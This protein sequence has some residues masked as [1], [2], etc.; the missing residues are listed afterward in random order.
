MQCCD[1]VSKNQGTGRDLAGKP[2]LVAIHTVKRNSAYPPPT[3]GGKK[4]GWQL[5]IQRLCTAVQVLATRE[6]QWLA[7]CLSSG[8]DGCSA[9]PSHD[10]AARM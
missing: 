4:R 9:L 8:V 2:T 3:P 1:A 6:M 10:V 5:L 7:L